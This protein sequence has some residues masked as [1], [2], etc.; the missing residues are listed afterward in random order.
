MSEDM[1]NRLK[2]DYPHF[3]HNQWQL[4]SYEAYDRGH[5]YGQ[6]EVDSIAIGIA[7]FVHNILKA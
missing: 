3:T 4:I 6:Q 1:L 7:Y 5:S 2:A